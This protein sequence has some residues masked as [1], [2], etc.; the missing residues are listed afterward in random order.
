M[1]F[2]ASSVSHWMG[3]VLDSSYRVKDGTTRRSSEHCIGVTPATELVLNR[4]SRCGGSIPGAPCLRTA[5][6]ATT[7]LPPLT[8]T[9]RTCGVERMVDAWF[10][11]LTNRVGMVRRENDRHLAIGSR[12]ELGKAGFRACRST[13]ARIVAGPGSGDAWR[14]CATHRTPNDRAERHLV[15]RSRPRRLT[16]GF[17]GP[18]VVRPACGWAMRRPPS[19]R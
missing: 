9:L 10:S 17:T 11:G 5:P 18:S 7:R 19:A 2:R 12:G 15:A 3:R 6:P 4:G 16:I 8:R 1:G 13:H 14:M